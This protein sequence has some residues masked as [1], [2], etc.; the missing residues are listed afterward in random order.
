MA[1]TS[2]NSYVVG[3]S[4]SYLFDN[5][6]LRTGYGSVDVLPIREYLVTLFE[7]IIKPQQPIIDV[8]IQGSQVK[9][10]DLTFIVQYKNNKGTPLSLPN[11]PR[12]AFIVR[13]D[14]GIVN[15]SIFPI[16]PEKGVFGAKYPG[17][18]FN[19]HG[20]YYF[21]APIQIEGMVASNG[22]FVFKVFEPYWEQKSYI[23]YYTTTL[24]VSLLLAAVLMAR[25]ERIKRARL[26]KSEKQGLKISQ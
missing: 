12:K 15:G 8:T 11:A 19:I 23:Y 3:F 7:Y 24:L 4:S 13:P 10:N 25:H 26:A 21:Y 5:F 16:D 6:Q 17:E 22:K 1:N 9:G 20:V 14:Y 18:I 2:S